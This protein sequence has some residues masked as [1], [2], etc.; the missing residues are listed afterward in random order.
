MIDVT[1]ET[2]EIKLWIFDYDND[3]WERV[4]NLCLEEDNWL[5]ENYLPHRCKV[6]DHKVFFIAYYPDGRP[7]MFG[8]I[9][10]YTNDVARVFNR[11][12]AFP[13]VRSVKKFKHHHGI[14]I[15][16]ILPALET[17][18][19]KTYNLLFVSMQM[20]E[21]T[22]K[23]NQKW[24]DFWKKS[25]FSWTQSDWKDFDGLVQTYPADNATCYQNIVYREKNNYTF[26]D[27]NPTRMSF[28][29]YN[30]RFV[31]V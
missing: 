20:R 22:Y 5:R 14:M 29:E 31:N 26:K 4:R 30:E 10:E 28:S 15:N 23:G 13:Y 24:W 1:L 3:E 27:W 6:S 18:I 19:D 21:R 25:W 11:M 2:N 8:G 17:A 12:Y 7:M 9:K 16:T